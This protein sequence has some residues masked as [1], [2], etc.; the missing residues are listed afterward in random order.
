MIASQRRVCSERGDDV[1]SAGRDCRIRLWDLELQKP[2]QT[3]ADGEEVYPM[4]LV[5]TGDA[6][7]LM[8]GSTTGRMD[9]WQLPSGKRELS[10]DAHKHWVRGEGDQGWIQDLT[11]FADGLRAVSASCDGTL[12]VWNLQSGRQTRC[13]DYNKAPLHAVAITPDE[14][15]VLT[16]FQIEDGHDLRHHP[17]GR[18]DVAAESAS[19]GR[20]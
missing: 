13:V 5:A 10:V 7:E 11:V 17:L 12:R 14:T 18:C 16:S 2:R 8:V 20:S 3:L 9:V 4:A 1:V 6:R 15:T 19:N